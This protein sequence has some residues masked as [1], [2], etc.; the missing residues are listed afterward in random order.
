MSPSVGKDRLTATHSR[1]IVR[2]RLMKDAATEG[3][4]QGM[5]PANLEEMCR[6]FTE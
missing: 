4:C 1:N 2:S 6:R 5:N 3:I